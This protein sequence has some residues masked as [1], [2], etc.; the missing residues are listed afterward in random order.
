MNEVSLAPTTTISSVPLDVAEKVAR[1]IDLSSTQ[2][3]ITFGLAEQKAASQVSEKMLTGVKTRDTGPIGES[4]NQM[5]REMKGMDLSSIANSKKPG[6]ISKL[7]GRASALQKFL[8]RYQTVES[9]IIKASNILET[10]RVQMLKDIT[11]MDSL[12]ESAKQHVGELD[13]QIA[14]LA[15]LIDDIQTNRIPPLED[16]A[17]ETQDIND[18]QALNE[19]R[20]IRDDL[21]IRKA[22]LLLIRNVTVQSLPSIKIIQANEKGLASKIQTQLTTGVNL[23]KSTMAVQIAAWRTQEAGEASKKATDYT[24]ELIETSAKQLQSANRI[25][26]KEI[27]RGVFDVSAAVNANETLI[28]TLQESMAIVEEGKAKRAEAERLL[29]DA[30]SKLKN[31]LIDMSK[32]RT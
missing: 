7:L 14:A 15:W 3:I 11:M 16:A 30:E 27:Q 10:H 17:K 26:A 25:A 19:M 29:T 2:S 31:T 1:S 4:M 13:I 20:N 18:V 24:N 28:S 22:D 5:V 32:K 6:F 9:Q 12:Y 21:E 23:W 8:D